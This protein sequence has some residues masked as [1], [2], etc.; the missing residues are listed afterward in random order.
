VLIAR[1]L[2]G[3]EKVLMVDGQHMAERCV[4]MALAISADG[5]K[6]PVGAGGRPHGEQTV[7]RSLLANLVERR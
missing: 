3:E 7:V 1:G 2:A 6:K 4:V 5:T